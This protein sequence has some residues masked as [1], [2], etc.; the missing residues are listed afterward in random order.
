MR[1]SKRLLSA[2]SAAALGVS[3]L[4]VLPLSAAAEGAVLY[5]NE[6]CTG[7]NG[8]NGNLTNATDNKG[9][10]C[11][12]GELYNPTDSAV[13]LSGWSLVK[14]DKSSYNFGDVTIAPGGY[15]I[16]FCCKNFVGDESL[17]NAGYNISGDG[18][19]FELF[20][21]DTS[22]DTVTVPALDKDVCFARKPD[23][24]ENLGY[25]FPTPAA[26]NNEAQSAIPCNAPEF[27]SDTG[28]YS[29]QFDLDITT[30][31]GNKVYYTTDG[32]DPRTSS[33]RIEFTKAITVKN[34]SS[35]AMKVA[36]AVSV[37]QVTPWS[38]SSL[39]RNSAVDKGT[40]IR[41]CTLSA[42]DEYSEVVTK[43]YFVGVSSAN[44]NGLPILSVTTDPDNLYNY[45]TGIFV[46]GAVYD[47]LT[48]AEKNV[49]NPEANYNQRGREWERECHIDFIEPDGTVGI[50]QDCGMRTQ[51]AY[52]RAAFQKSLRFY[53][54]EDYGEKNFKYEVFAGHTKA[55][56]SGEVLKKFKTLVARQ[57][58][59]DNEYCK[60][61]DSYI[62][63]LVS[64]R[65]F[66]TQTGRPCVMFIDGEYWG[67]YTLQED[68]NDNY[69]E[70]NYG[71][72]NNEVI[73][74]KKGEIDEGEETDIQYAEELL[75]YAKKYN[76]ALPQCYEQISQMMDIDSFID[77][78]AAEMYIINEDWPGNNYSMW[79][80]RT[81]DETN[82]YA[83][84]RWRMNFYDT[85]MGVDHYGNS[86]TKYNVDNLKKIT[87]NTW[88]YLPILFN[89]L[90]KNAEF[91]QKFVTAMCDEMNV[92]FNYT[93]CNDLVTAF[94]DAYFPELPKNYARYP[95]W[96]NVDNAASPCYSRMMNFLKNRPKYVPTMLKNNLGLGTAVTVKIAPIEQQG[97][98]VKLN[99]TQLDFEYG[100]FSGTYFT[101]YPITLT[102]EAKEGYT[103]IGWSGDVDS[104]EETITVDLKG[105]TLIQPL[106]VNSD[107]VLHT[108]T[109]TDGTKSSR[110]YVAD[111]QAASAP[112]ET[113]AKKGYT[114]SWDKDF[115]NITGDIT[116]NA[117]Y[118]PFKYTVRFAP[119]G[120]PYVSYGQDFVYGEEQALMPLAFD[121]DG[122][123][124]KGW[125]SS[126]KGEVIYADGEKVSNL[127]DS[128]KVVY[129]YAVWEKDTSVK[130]DI[131]GDGKLDTKDAMLSIS[132]A[133]KNTAPKDSAQFKRADVNGD[134]VLDTKDSLVI[135]KAAKNKTTIK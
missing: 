19:K 86:S 48:W 109:F 22:V 91:K 57:G 49:D 29:S 24:S 34:R 61:K 12:W 76:L 113:F 38:G 66:E 54:R 39:P 98:T 116:V 81:V 105:S 64:D 84:G 60:F 134:G 40:V 131:N 11:D 130:G 52:S 74:Y 112:D 63:S 117:V 25:F 70:N 75:N 50:S 58:G 28:F 88:D 111:G 104:K 72:D 27:S 33:T 106:F 67:L 96:A 102:A 18:A 79:R 89:N 56:G 103:F 78:M 87:D 46:K 108:V 114:L 15:Q 6:V 120:A 69:Y 23:G 26:S 71:V 135:I 9:A 17:V 101:D 7:N 95:N 115:S 35:E 45:N 124:F 80:T 99:T 93:R 14:D 47:S 132:Y 37:D 128:A 13:S 32:T 3:S 51:G 82:P 65:A 118:E 31:E 4:A 126:S 119:N 8:E 94:Y 127:S 133:K 83:D 73:V 16:V 30:D 90:M 10:Y 68:Y 42:A 41:A 62:Q 43:S 125:A 55:D 110:V 59:N 123:I 53:A 122:Y 1:I 77:Y 107:T 2:A 129:L 97:G 20:N 100:D 21:G 85:E 5:I 44:H 36:N 121:Y 92:N